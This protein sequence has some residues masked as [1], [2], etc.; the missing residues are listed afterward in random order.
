MESITPDTDLVKISRSSNPNS[1]FSIF[2]PDNS[3]ETLST[4]LIN[5]TLPVPHLSLYSIPSFFPPGNSLS[6]SLSALSKRF[7]SPSISSFFPPTQSQSN[8]LSTHRSSHGFDHTIPSIFQPNYSCSSSNASTH[9]LD[10]CTSD[11]NKLNHEF[12]EV[13]L[14]KVTHWCPITFDNLDDNDERVLPS[15]VEVEL[16]KACEKWTY[17]IYWELDS[18]SYS[19][20]KNIRPVKGFF[21]IDNQKFRNNDIQFFKLRDST[22]MFTFGSVLCQVFSTSSPIWVVGEDC[23]ASSRYYRARLGSKY[24][25]QTMSWI[26]VVDGVMEFGSTELIHPT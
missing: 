14:S 4:S 13:L 16:G 1:I 24:G 5:E 25:L 8:S 23:L 10:Q 21:N 12:K 20:L 7:S 6:S 18:L 3:N 17:A 26:R 19:S 2:P 11:A 9:D 15:E 22:P